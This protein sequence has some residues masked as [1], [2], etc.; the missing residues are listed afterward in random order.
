MERDADFSVGDALALVSI[1]FDDVCQRR[2]R[3]VTNRRANDG[4]EQNVVDENR[5]VTDD[6]RIA[7]QRFDA[8]IL[9]GTFSLE[10]V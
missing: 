8:E 1:E 9:T 2:R 6:R 5:D 4:G 10:R 3:G 7:R